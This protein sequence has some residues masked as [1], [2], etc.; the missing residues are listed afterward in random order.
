MS[1]ILFVD[2]NRDAADAL[3]DLAR[4]LG[5]VASVAY[6]GATAIQMTSRE[7]F[8]LVCLDV[9]LP[10]ADGRDI[11][12]QIRGGSRAH[13]RIVAITGYSD[14]QHSDDMKL[15]DDCVVKPVTVEQLE[16]LLADV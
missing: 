3:A 1:K 7:S 10:D 5:H 6:D 11:C 16:R 8:D 13:G 12:H 2:D 4:A 9:S 14:L 15:F